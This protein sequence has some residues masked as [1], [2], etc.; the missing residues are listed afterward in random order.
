MLI[1]YLPSLSHCTVAGHY[2][3]VRASRP[4]R[5]WVSPHQDHGPT[6]ETLAP[7]SPIFW[8]QI[9]GSGRAV[10]SLRGKL[11]R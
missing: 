8:E 5:H 10:L 2:L 11:P 1:N 3:F 9:F 7:P 6:R 4:I